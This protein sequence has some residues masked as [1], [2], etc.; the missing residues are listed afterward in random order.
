MHTST[1]PTHGRRSF[2]S[3]AACAAVSALGLPM[4]GGCGSRPDVGARFSTGRIAE[5]G[6]ARVNLVTGSERRQLV[7]EALEPLADEV[8]AAIQG[9]QVLI[10][11]NF[12]GTGLTTCVT[13]P[14]A[15]RGVLDFLAPIYD[16]PV[17]VAESKGFK[18]SF[19]HYGYLPLTREYDVRLEELHTGRLSRQWIL[20]QNMQPQSIRV[21][22]AYFDPNLYIISLTRIKSHNAVVSTLT[23]KNVVMGVPLKW[24]DKNINDKSKMHA[25]S[26]SP[27]MLNYNLFHM[28]HMVHPHLSVLDAYEGV[29]GNGPVSDE[30][31]D[32][33]VA[34]AGT[35][36]VAVDRIGTELMGVPFEKVGYLT[37]CAQ[38]GLGQGTRDRIVVTG[39]NPA[40]HI[41]KYK[42][43]Q[44]VD[45][46]YH[47]D[48]EIPWPSKS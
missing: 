25:G 5:P 14:D 28:A 3:T 45:F 27:K 38:Y 6:T 39:E 31:V 29:E 35:D 32:H 15:V 21:I 20:D 43:H 1:I 46:Q 37:Y 9:R 33:R 13:H 30:V 10:K 24:P 34:L 47:W 12:V 17:I 8:A 40:D 2:L 22:D 23:L 26:V 19:E 4:L 16:R 44:N 42:L 36:F 18:P 48:D 41:R 7:R 11:V